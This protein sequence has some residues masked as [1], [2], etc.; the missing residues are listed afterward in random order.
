MALSLRAALHEP[1]L[2]FGSADG[3]LHVERWP[4]Y[5]FVGSA[6]LC[7]SA[8][9]AFHLIGTANTR[10]LAALGAW[11]YAGIVVLILGST[12]PIYHYAFYNDAFYRRLYLAAICS[13]G[14][15]LLLF[16]QLEW[17][18]TNRWRLL[19]IG[20][21]VSL[22]AVGAL[23]LAHVLVLHQ[24]NAMSVQLVSGVGAMGVVYMVGVYIYATGFPEAVRGGAWNRRGQFDVHLSSHQFWHVAVVAAAYLH[25]LTVVELWHATSL[26]HA[27]ATLNATAPP[28]LPL[29]VPAACA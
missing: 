4:L 21:F 1:Q 24:F 7:L 25:F 17:F 13:C 5:V 6:M 10:W 20:L 11:D 18:Y 3:P 15:V 16:V 28:P 29:L 9:A 26:S 12:I 23:P 27:A 22:G 2:R 19:R 14:F 8:S